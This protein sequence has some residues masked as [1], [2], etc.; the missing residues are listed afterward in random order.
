MRWRVV[1]RPHWT[2]VPAEVLT[3]IKGKQEIE[4]T[5]EEIAHMEFLTEDLL[6]EQVEPS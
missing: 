3:Q 4:A 1:S 5:E 2:K 6:F